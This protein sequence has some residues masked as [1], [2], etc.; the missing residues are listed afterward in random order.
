MS[1]KTSPAG[2]TRLTVQRLARLGALILTLTGN[3]NTAVGQGNDNVAPASVE[4]AG[5]ALEEGEPPWYFY[6]L[7]GL[8]G[9]M[10]LVG[11]GARRGG[12][13]ASGSLPA[14]REPPGP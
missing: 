9:F 11:V 6:S 12:R 4:G 1:L 3:V 2:R 14:R 13:G 7:W 5:A 10:V 8:A